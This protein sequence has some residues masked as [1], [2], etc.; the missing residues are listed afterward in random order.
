MRCGREKQRCKKKENENK[1]ELRGRDNTES[2][3]MGIEDA[4]RGERGI[5]NKDQSWEN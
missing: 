2:G 3:T 5:K 4:E 1:Q